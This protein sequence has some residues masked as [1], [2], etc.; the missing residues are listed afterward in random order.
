MIIKRKLYSGIEVVRG[1]KWKFV[2]PKHDIIDAKLAY[3][4]HLARGGEKE[5]ERFM[6]LYRKLAGNK[7]HKFIQ[8][9]K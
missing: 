4:K 5:G 1:K 9:I 6:A 8:K 3:E 2:I 7:P